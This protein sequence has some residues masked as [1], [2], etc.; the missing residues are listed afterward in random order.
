MGTY[1]ETFP[2]EAFCVKFAR[3][4]DI[5]YMGFL[6]NRQASI[7]MPHIMRYSRV[8]AGECVDRNFHINV[9]L[10][11]YFTLLYVQ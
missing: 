11:V 5:Q 9:N 8:V 1:R 2:F 7:C 10:L 4:Q 3:R 6:L